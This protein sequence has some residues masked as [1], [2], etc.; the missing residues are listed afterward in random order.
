VGSEPANII[1]RA[2][3]KT[4]KHNAT[5]NK[6]PFCTSSFLNLLTNSLTLKLK[7][8]LILATPSPTHLSVHFK[9]LITR[10]I[11]ILR[12]LLNGSFIDKV[13]F[14]NFYGFTI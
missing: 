10:F 6:K 9:V 14:V 2:V 13:N 5:N 4:A 1:N 8:P 3:D 12:L 11:F 7:S